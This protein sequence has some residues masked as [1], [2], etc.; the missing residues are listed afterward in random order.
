MANPLEGIYI[1]PVQIKKNNKIYKKT[2]MY[3]ESLYY[4]YCLCCQS[5]YN[6]DNKTLL[7]FISHLTNLTETNRLSLKLNCK[8]AFS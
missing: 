6:K 3:L 1:I 4:K 2:F 7:R 5:S 8:N